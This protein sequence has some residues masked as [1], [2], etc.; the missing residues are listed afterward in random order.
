MEAGWPWSLISSNPFSVYHTPRRDCIN[1]TLLCH[2]L[3][4]HTVCSCEIMEKNSEPPPYP[5]DPGSGAAYPPYPP[6]TGPAH[7]P[8]TQY[9]VNQPVQ[10][11]VGP[12]HPPPIQYGVNQPVQTQVVTVIGQP[13]LTDV[14]GQMQC[15][16]CQQEIVTQIRH[17]SGL[18]T[19]LLCGGMFLFLCWP[20][21]FIPFCV[22]GCKDVEHSCPNCHRL[23]YRYKRL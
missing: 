6:P 21:S 8:P 1:L 9:G 16:Q 23:L 3:H 5:A 4:T 22:D 7:P 13:M 14:P 15:P 10:T 2:L 12:A 17:T 19:W 18:L 20:C 11:Q